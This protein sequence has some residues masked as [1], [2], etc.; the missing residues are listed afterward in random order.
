MAS[1]GKGVAKGLAAGTQDYGNA[2]Q[3]ALALYMRRKENEA[4]R[5]LREGLFT[6]NLAAEQGAAQA[7]AAAEAAGIQ[8]SNAILQALQS[9]TLDQF[10]GA[11]PPTTEKGLGTM[12]SSMKE[13]RIRAGKTP[14][15]PEIMD[16]Q[17]QIATMAFDLLRGM[18]PEG[19][20]PEASDFINARSQAVMAASQ[21][22][23]NLNMDEIKDALELFD[24]STKGMVSEARWFGDLQVPS[25]PGALAP[26]M[27]IPTGK[28]GGT[29]PEGEST[30]GRF[31]GDGA[32]RAEPPV[33]A[34]IQPYM[35]VFAAPMESVR[36]YLKNAVGSDEEVQTK[37]SAAV[38][39]IG[40]EA[41]DRKIFIDP[42][43]GVI[44]EFVD[45]MVDDIMQNQDD[46]GL[47]IADLPFLNDPN[48]VLAIV[49]L[50]LE[51]AMSELKK[52][53]EARQKAKAEGTHKGLM[54]EPI[55]DWNLMNPSFGGTW[56]GSSFMRRGN[57]YDLSQ[58]S[59]GPPEG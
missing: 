5:Q 9:G 18:V 53:Y 16:K 20:T 32:E 51:D 21:P 33:P 17:K 8:E 41:L 57:L 25:R 36:S 22:P 54:G 11:T 6:Q 15:S 46:L 42:R 45:E 7:K 40:L 19:E 39:K 44:E 3:N 30:L 12:M 59:E 28:T 23:Y 26:G 49:R 35:D 24:Q 31:L 58:L 14:P 13:Q 34:T 38:E 1:F 56:G 43:E 50:G 4:D 2:I 48:M 52:E 55:G 27:G 29:V 10:L 37:M 47:D